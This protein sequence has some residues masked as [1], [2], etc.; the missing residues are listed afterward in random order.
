[1]DHACYCGLRNENGMP[2]P[3]FFARVAD[4]HLRE[5]HAPFLCP[6]D[7]ISQILYFSFQHCLKSEMAW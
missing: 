3:P 4:L 2:E 1:M 5:D 7:L 6:G